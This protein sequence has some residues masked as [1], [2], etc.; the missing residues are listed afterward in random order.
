MFK[1]LVFVSCFVFISCSSKDE[2]FCDCLKQSE[3]LN[4]FSNK[5]LNGT[6]NETEKAKLKDLQAKKLKAC[7]AYKTMKGDEMIRLKKACN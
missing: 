4:T 3:T 6:I 2:K 7:E 5:I 1:V